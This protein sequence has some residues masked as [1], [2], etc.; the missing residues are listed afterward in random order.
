MD[1]DVIIMIAA[2]PFYA[3]A[4][5]VVAYLAAYAFHKAKELNDSAAEQAITELPTGTAAK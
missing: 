5:V 3:L 4:L 1:T 2:I